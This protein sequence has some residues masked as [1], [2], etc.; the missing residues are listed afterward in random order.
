M[1]IGSYDLVRLL[2]K[3][4]MADVYLGRAGHHLAAVKL[5]N[6]RR[7]V[8]PEASAMFVD[9]TRL[10]L[11][12]DH[13]NIAATYEVGLAEDGTPYA[14]MELVHGVDL[15]GLLNTAAAANRRIAYEASLAIVMAAAAGLE[16]AHRRRGPD[17]Q[18]LRLVHRDVS[19][20]NLMVGHDGAVKLLDFGIASTTVQTVHTA[21]GIV[22][23][24]ASYM[25]PEQCLGEAIDHRADV[26][27]LGVVLYELT[28]GM[29]CFHG[30]NDFERMVAVVRGEYHLPSTIHADYPPGLEWIVRRALARDPKVRYQTC[31]DLAAALGELATHSGWTVNVGPILRT[32]RELYGCVPA[33][34]VDASAGGQGLGGPAG[35]QSMTFRA[36]P[37]LARG[38]LSDRDTSEQ[39]VAPDLDDDDEPT[40][41]RPR[42]RVS[43]LAI[44]PGGN[45]S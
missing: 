42:A 18:P 26:F 4:G 23:G 7:A 2:A 21:P 25:A 45:C 36:Q 31:A 20:S 13:P 22:R 19:L 28:T 14:V 35:P 17:G 43:S 9:E 5:L 34:F 37:R 6:P 30:T 10:G 24:K 15:R 29:R 40:R 33:P 3:G 44:A 32:M 38:T 27:A 41:G 8:A 1:R 39:V 12:L 16:H 11:L